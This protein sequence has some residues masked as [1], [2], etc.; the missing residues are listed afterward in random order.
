VNSGEEVLPASVALAKEALNKAGKKL[1]EKIPQ[2]SRGDMNFEIKASADIDTLAGNIG[3]VLVTMMG[4]RKV[5]KS[6]QT[7]IQEL[8]TEWAKKTIPFVET[9][10]TVA[11]V[12]R[13]S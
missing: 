10:L 2:D 4:D 6:K 9:G 1:A 3:S 8:V 7:H 13:T 11:N 12:Y 5:D